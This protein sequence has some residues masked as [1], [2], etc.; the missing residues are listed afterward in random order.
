[1]RPG[2]FLTVLI[3]IVIAPATLALTVVGA[4]E[5]S[6][7]SSGSA[8]DVAQAS[9]KASAPCSKHALEA[10][11][12]RAHSHARIATKHSFGCG[13]GFA[14]AFAIVGRGT[15]AF[16]ENLLFRAS[17]RRW[18]VVSRAKYCNKPVVPERVKK[19]V[20]FSS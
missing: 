17:G 5:A 4:P 18:N 1:M 20:C 6:L 9:A 3:T 2:Y 13:R 19:A 10:A 7:A 14:Y 15:T 12:K 8:S 11:M 16:E